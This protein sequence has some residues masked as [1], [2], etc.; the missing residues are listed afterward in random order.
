MHVMFP[1]GGMS[2]FLASFSSADCSALEAYQSR[3]SGKAAKISAA[4]SA[5]T[6]KQFVTIF[7]TVGEFCYGIVDLF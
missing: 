6:R 3:H 5:I 7:G 1:C 4:C 2:G